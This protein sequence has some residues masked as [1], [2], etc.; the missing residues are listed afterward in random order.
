MNDSLTY[1]KKHQLHPTTSQL[2]QLHV[3]LF[4]SQAHILPK[5]VEKLISNTIFK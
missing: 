4:W 2:L 3:F 5:I 1:N